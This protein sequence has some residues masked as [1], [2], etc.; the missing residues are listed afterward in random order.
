MAISQKIIWKYE[1]PLQGEYLARSLY[2]G[3]TPGLVSPL[4]V[5]IDAEGAKVSIKSSFQCYIRPDNY[6]ED[7]NTQGLLVK[8]DQ[9]ISDGDI[10]SYAVLEDNAIALGI[11]YTW[12][13]DTSQEAVIETLYYDDVTD[14]LTDY[15]G[16]ILCCFDKV[17]K[18]V[19]PNMADFTLAYSQTIPALSGVGYRGL[20]P[21]EFSTATQGNTADRNIQ[22]LVR[23]LQYSEGLVK[24]AKTVVPVSAVV[25]SDRI[26]K[27]FYISTPEYIKVEV[28]RSTT[29]PAY[30]ILSYANT[31][32]VNSDED[33]P[34]SLSILYSDLS[35]SVD[36][37]GLPSEQ[38]ALVA[39]KRSSTIFNS[40]DEE[41]VDISGSGVGSS[42]G[43]STFDNQII[44]ERILVSDVDASG[45]VAANSSRGLY[46]NKDV[47]Y[48]SPS[49][50][51][52]VEKPDQIYQNGVPT[53][54]LNSYMVR[55]LFHCQPFSF[56]RKLSPT[57]TGT[58]EVFSNA[59]YF[60]FPDFSIAFGD[61]VPYSVSVDGFEGSFSVGRKLP[62]Y[63]KDCFCF[64]YGYNLS[65]SVYGEEE[66]VYPDYLVQF[67]GEWY[68]P[69]KTIDDFSTNTGQDI[70]ITEYNG[71]HNIAGMWNRPNNELQVTIRNLPL[72]A[73]AHKVIISNIGS[74][75]ED[76]TNWLMEMTLTYSQSGDDFRGIIFFDN[77]DGKLDRV[78]CLMRNS[79]NGRIGN[80]MAFRVGPNNEDE[81]SK[82]TIVANE[83]VKLGFLFNGAVQ[84]DNADFFFDGELKTVSIDNPDILTTKSPAIIDNSLTLRF[85]QEQVD[86]AVGSNAEGTLLIKKIAFY[87]PYKP[88]VDTDDILVST[89]CCGSGSNRFYP[90]IDKVLVPEISRLEDSDVFKGS[91]YTLRDYKGSTRDIHYQSKALSQVQANGMVI[92]K[93]SLVPEV[94]PDWYFGVFDLPV[95]PPDVTGIEADSWNTE[96]DKPKYRFISGALSACEVIAQ[97]TIDPTQRFMRYIL[98]SPFTS[99]SAGTGLSR[100]LQESISSIDIVHFGHS[101]CYGFDKGTIGSICK[102]LTLDFSAKTP[103]T[104]IYTIGDLDGRA[105]D[106]VLDY[107]YYIECSGTGTGYLNIKTTENTYT[108]KPLI[109]IKNRCDSTIS[110]R[111]GNNS[112]GVDIPASESVYLVSF[113]SAKGDLMR[114]RVYAS[115][116]FSYFA[117]ASEQVSDESVT[118]SY[119]TSFEKGLYLGMSFN[120]RMPMI[121]SKMEYEGAGSKEF[122]WTKPAMFQYIPKITEGSDTYWAVFAYQ[123]MWTDKRPASDSVPCFAKRVYSGAKDTFHFGSIIDKYKNLVSNVPKGLSSDPAVSFKENVY[124]MPTFDFPDSQGVKCNPYIMHCVVP[125]GTSFNL[126]Y[127]GTETGYRCG[128]ALSQATVIPYSANSETG[129]TDSTDMDTV[130][131]LLYSS[132]DTSL[133]ETGG[134]FFGTVGS[135]DGYFCLVANDADKVV[136][137]LF[138]STTFLNIV[139]EVVVPKVAEEVQK[140]L[141]DLPNRVTEVETGLADLRAQTGQ[142][143]ANLEIEDEHRYRYDF[144]VDDEESWQ[145]FVRNDM[146]GAK[147]VLI[148]KGAWT[149]TTKV[150]L[151]TVN[152]IRLEEGAKV[153]FNAGFEGSSSFLVTLFG[154]LIRGNL[155]NCR[156]LRATIT[157]LN[158][159]T[160]TTFENTKIE[161]SYVYINEGSIVGGHYYR[162]VFNILGDLSDS[163]FFDCEIKNVF[164]LTNCTITHSEIPNNTRLTNCTVTDCDIIIIIQEGTVFFLAAG[165]STTFINCRVHIYSTYN[166]S[167]PIISSGTVFRNCKLSINT[168]NPSHVQGSAYDCEFLSEDSEG[169]NFSFYNS[170]S[171]YGNSFM[172]VDGSITGLSFEGLAFYMR[173]ARILTDSPFYISKYRSYFPVYQS[174]TRLIPGVVNYISNEDDRALYTTTGVNNYFI[175]YEGQIADDMGVRISY[176]GYT[177]IPTALISSKY[178]YI[179]ITI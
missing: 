40:Q 137:N 67:N 154:G 95:Y 99:Y 69:V 138:R 172:C 117:D 13:S 179:K 136:T 28:C 29:F 27:T 115:P 123:E 49:D 116:A 103:D 43:A 159:S 109:F 65:P 52:S 18:R 75:G 58:T 87:R 20:L 46:I 152:M 72:E 168:V 170:M 88:V 144:V 121:Y 163:K 127:Y 135:E 143:I 97:A 64:W 131:G 63:G 128:I 113:V 147:S 102:E 111:Y 148:R 56:N 77:S 12:V 177:F 132:L 24:S 14:D 150:T 118:Y 42:D 73:S 160:S 70:Q 21:R 41:V 86:L 35:E 62:D 78:W 66:I 149:A 82:Y 9:E 84:G 26:S 74:V 54:L 142:Q 146:G 61:E 32:Y 175:Q 79:F 110:V 1:T 5:E 76:M 139:E 96:K 47:L 34:E 10:L 178:G 60:G 2:G 31:Y 153:L 155:T 38:T 129:G 8:V 37:I 166:I 105:Q 156:V 83:E 108:F 162:S 167:N 141:G 51:F 126:D 98:S 174:S 94:Y 17:N 71:N 106:K 173:R 100:G 48:F 158:D 176:G 165:G 133:R 134:T 91:R 11:R 39:L 44:T 114:P 85:A 4:D 164:R 90:P 36:K 140:Q 68:E 119:A 157:T 104:I 101:Y 15:K 107:N 169:H 53:T 92:D 55:A 120:Q 50:D 33:V 151:R 124:K 171:I 93:N 161:D 125:Y 112:F 23:Y 7:E 57:N 81:S 25:G 19:Y 22:A 6:Y 130:S 45:N 3:I 59:F 16:V 145:K 80:G 89:R 122:D 30:Q